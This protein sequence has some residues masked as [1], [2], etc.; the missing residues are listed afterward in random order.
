MPCV[1]LP[2]LEIAPF[3][4]IRRSF[5]P[6]RFSYKTNHF[7]HTFMKKTISFL[8]VLAAGSMLTAS[9]VLMLPAPTLTK[10]EKSQG[11]VDI[12]WEFSSD[13]APKPQFQVIVYKMHKAAADEEFVLAQTG[14]DNIESTGTIR[15]HEERGAI[16]D[17]LPDC[18]GWFAK[19]PLYMNGALGIDTQNYFVGADNDDTFGGAYLVSPDYDLSH[20]TSKKLKIDA[21]LAREASSVT[22]GFALYIWNTEWWDEKNIDY[23]ASDAHDHHYDDLSD[24]K[25][26]P[27]SEVCELDTFS[28]PWFVDRT[29]VCFYGRGH[30]AYWI[31]SL[32]VAVDLKAG[33]YLHYG[34]SVHNVGDARSFTI[35]TSADTDNDYVYGYEVRAMRIDERTSYDPEGNEKKNDY[36]RFISPS[37]PMKVIG[38]DAG[39]GSIGADDYDAPEEYYSLQGMRLSE[40]VKG[41]IVIVRKGSKAYKTIIR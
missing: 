9:A 6:T 12:A 30:S 4:Q 24:T 23:K 29:R 17:Y 25:F 22:G 14:F 32:R 16:W 3:F 18:P 13:D 35:D 34:A 41:Q 31:D 39:I 7:K 11:K 2:K 8:S 10:E 21:T 19:M 1:R 36:I 38:V 40:P 33:D 20:V 27:Y 28:N 15:K 26:K 37:K 5:G